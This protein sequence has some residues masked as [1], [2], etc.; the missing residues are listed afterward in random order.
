MVPISDGISQVGPEHESVPAPLAA[1]I[2]VMY[3]A[4]LH[5][6]KPLDPEELP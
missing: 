3:P 1:G 2:P 5:A 6:N 4:L